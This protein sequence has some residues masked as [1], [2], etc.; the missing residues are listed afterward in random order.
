[1]GFG[2]MGEAAT[3]QEDSR[4]WQTLSWVLP[5]RVP[6]GTR[7]YERV[8][9]SAEVPT[10]QQPMVTSADSEAAQEQALHVAEGVLD[11]LSR[12]LL[13][14]AVAAGGASS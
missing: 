9:V 4:L 11:R 5:V 13:S 8:L 7:R 14:G 1:M 6:D 12:E 10:S 2:L 3:W